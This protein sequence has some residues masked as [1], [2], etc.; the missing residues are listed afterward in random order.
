LSLSNVKES[1]PAS[2]VKRSPWNNFAAKDA[3]R[4][5]LTGIPRG[6][7]EEFWATG[8]NTVRDELLPIIEQLGVERGTALEIGCGLGRLLFPMARHFKKV[9]GIDIAPEMIR[10]ASLLA[11]E[12]NVSNAEL[13]SISELDSSLSRMRGLD[14]GVDFIYSLLVFQHIE[15]FAF[16]E[17]YLG[18]VRSWL[19]SNGGAYLQFDTRTETLL[20]RFKNVLPESILPSH[21]RR[22]IRR[23]RRKPAD[24]ERS[25]RRF[26]LTITKN[27]GQLS[28]YHCYVLKADQSWGELK[29]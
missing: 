12:R 9:V 16:I 1:I 4:Y 21:L 26:G 11:A 24:L 13:F 10:Q 5:I 2:P 14:S 22:G 17:Q 7:R 6:D 23:I 19:S 15:E 25:F 3:Y 18:F 28:K 8:E 29:Q 27:I 20:Y